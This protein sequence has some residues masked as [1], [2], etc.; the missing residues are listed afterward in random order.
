MSV[1]VE[2][3][4]QQSHLLGRNKV[5]DER[6]RAFALP[7]TP[8]DR[9][10]WRDKK[11]RIY[12]PRPNPNQPVGC[13]TMCAKAMQLNAAGNRKAGRV[14]DMDWALDGYVWETHN[15]PFAGAWNRDG[16]GE[17]TGSN[18]LASCKT[19]QHTGDGAE[20]QWIFT[21]AD[22]IIQAV[23]DGKAISVGTKWY[24]DM[25]E[26][27]AKGY[28]N[29][30]GGMVGGHQWIVRGYDLSED[31]AFGLC[32]W[33]RFREFKIKRT[34]LDGLVRDG[35]DAHWQRTI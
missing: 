2:I 34:A 7:T 15:D 10:T 31:A 29:P 25:F 1:D 4:E 3:Y 32:W 9:S 30:T 23:M 19:A 28:L 11:I 21:G 8:I 22:G 12:D 35:G 16:S 5:H 26:V 20:Y 18:G 14:L 17:D 6:S 13:C 27:D 24:G 33:G